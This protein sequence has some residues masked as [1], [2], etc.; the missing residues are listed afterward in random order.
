MQ[1]NSQAG[2]ITTH[3]LDTAAGRPAEGL[4]LELRRFETARWNDLGRFQT[5]VDGRCDTPL[6]DGEAMRAGLYEILFHTGDWRGPAAGFYDVIP[7]R[8]RITDPAAH[9]HVPLI[10]SPFGY[11]TYRGS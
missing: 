3:V 5:N 4:V 6:L 1:S 2:R 7:I 10:L 11:S 8:F 9:H